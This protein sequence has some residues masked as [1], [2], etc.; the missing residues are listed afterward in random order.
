M[1]VQIHHWR[2]VEKAVYLVISL[3]GPAATE[4]TN[5]QQDLYQDY[6]SLITALQSQFGT[7][8]QTELNR[9]RLKIQTREWEETLLELAEDVKLLVRSAY[10]KATLSMVEV[11]AKDHFV[12]AR[13]D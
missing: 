4:S 5:L 6:T 13:P 12:D 10:P 11:L 1:L 9:M 2:D 3:R 7:A 8:H